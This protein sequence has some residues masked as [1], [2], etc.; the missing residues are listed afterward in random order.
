ME[1]LHYYLCAQKFETSLSLKIELRIEREIRKENE[2]ERKKNIQGKYIKVP[3][4]LPT[5]TLF[6]NLF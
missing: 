4:I 5:R 6:E 1:F 2:M 3:I